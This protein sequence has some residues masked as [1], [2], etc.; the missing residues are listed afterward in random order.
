MVDR[1]LLHQLDNCDFFYKESAS[2]KKLFPKWVWHLLP[3]PAALLFGLQLFDLFTIC[4]GLSPVWYRYPCHN[5][6]SPEFSLASSTHALTLNLQ[7]LAPSRYI[8]LLCFICL[9]TLACFVD[10]ELACLP[11]RGTDYV[12][13]HTRDSGYKA[14]HPILTTSHRLCVHVTWWIC[15]TISNAHSNVIQKSTHQ[16]SPCPQL[17]LDCI[18]ADD[19]W[20]CACTPWPIYCC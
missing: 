19:I 14:S 16:S 2:R 3:L 20:K 9:V 7:W 4:P 10:Y 13:S 18:T 8:F 12:C 11:N 15:C 17:C 1:D 5:P 6:A